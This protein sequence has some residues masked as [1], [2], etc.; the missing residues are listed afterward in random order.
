MRINLKALFALLL[1]FFFAADYAEAQ[2]RRRYKPKRFKSSA[3]KYRG[4]RSS[5]GSGRFRPYQYVG[6]GINALN[7]FGDLAPVSKA[8]ST[9]ISFTK[10]GFGLMYGYR[11]HP[12]V[13]ARVVYNWGALKGDDFSADPAG[14]FSA[15][16]HQRNL[17]FRNFINELSL[18]F[19]FYFIPNYR[20]PSL[21]PPINAYLFLGFGAF[22][23][24][25]QGKA[26][27]FDYQLGTDA[28]LPGGLTPGQWVDLQPLG[29]EGQNLGSIDL[30]GE[31]VQFE[32]PYSLWSFAIPIGLGVQ[33]ALPG[34]LNVGLELGYRFI[35]TDYLDDVSTNYVGLEVFDDP[36]ARLF[37]DRSIEPVAVVDGSPREV[38]FVNTFERDGITYNYNNNIGSGFT[39]SKRGNPDSNDLYFVTQIRLTY[40]ISTNKRSNA[41]FR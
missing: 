23:H 2:G 25:P 15:A 26:P 39:G 20:D 35:F 1:I 19:E 3:S 12:A 6:V 9:D 22:R 18:G 21:R 5:G 4:G 34:N 16:R 14:E 11:F 8:A 31:S 33:L 30:D 17:S 13:A 24:N 27:A 29:T 7:Y 40:I 10:P 36:I 41:K 32:S 28:Q 37:S 38:L